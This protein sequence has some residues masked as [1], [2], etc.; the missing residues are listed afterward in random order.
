MPNARELPLRATSVQTALGRSF[1]FEPQTFA[2]KGRGLD[3]G[4]FQGPAVARAPPWQSRRLRFG[5]TGRRSAVRHATF[6]ASCPCR[7]LCGAP[8][9]V[10][11]CVLPRL[12]PCPWALRGR[13]RGASVADSCSEQQCS[14]TWGVVPGAVGPVGDLPRPR[15]AR[16]MIY[17]AN[18][19]NL[20]SPTYS[21]K[22]N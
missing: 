18:L 11:P 7:D 8:C 21:T 1:D 17:C 19:L 9:T 14:H 10:T 2:V 5:A 13:P 6:H 12:S 16:P 3:S 4:P 20:G 22:L 15:A